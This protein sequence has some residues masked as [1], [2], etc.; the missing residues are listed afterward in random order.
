M[1]YQYVYIK[2]HRIHLLNRY[3]NHFFFKIRGVKSNSSFIKNRYFHQ[4]FLPFLDRS[5]KLESKFKD[6]FNTFKKLNDE[7]KAQFNDLVRIGI[8]VEK[9]FED[10][11]IQ[12]VS[13]RVENIKSILGNDSLKVLMDYL[14]TTTFKSSSFNLKDHYQQMYKY[15]P[16]KI[17]PFCGIEMMHKTY[18]ED[19]DHIAP[20]SKYPLI[21]INLKNLAPMCHQCNSKFKQEIDIYYNDGKRRPYA[22]P[23]TTTLEI[24]LDFT[25]S[26]IEQ[27]DSK[28]YNGKW[29]IKILPEQ[30][31]TKTWNEV[32]HLEERYK[33][34]Y[35][36]AKFQDWMNE[37]F[38]SIKMCQTSIDTTEELI[39]QFT[40]AAD[41]FYRNRFN[42]LNIIK[43]PL[44]RFLGSGELIEFYNSI[45]ML[46]KER[47]AA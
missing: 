31:L 40:I 44:F 35:L 47:F 26:I 43:A 12:C 33:T 30:P 14:Y 6:F 36:E 4:D 3:L 19:Y 39:N 22:Y 21:A 37:F 7:K 17:C 34:D 27:T 1:L 46:F 16:Y 20:K 13:M 23:Y 25:G 5:E 28:D 15:M 9:S 8:T 24:D 42:N 2:K 41:S 32:F 38:E 11:D 18:Q 45:L 10:T 29:C